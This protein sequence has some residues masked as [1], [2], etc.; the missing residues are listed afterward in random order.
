MRLSVDVKRQD[1]GN[2]KRKRGDG[3]ENVTLDD[4]AERDMAKNDPVFLPLFYN[5]QRMETHG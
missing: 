5:S 4:L 1:K 3:T 2:V